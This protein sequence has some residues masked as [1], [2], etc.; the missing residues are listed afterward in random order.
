MD[1]ISSR[2]LKEVKFEFLI[3]NF[4]SKCKVDHNMFMLAQPN[5]HSTWAHSTTVK[6]PF[7]LLILAKIWITS[8][9]KFKYSRAQFES[10]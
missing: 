10:K 6:G 1:C 4:A 3:L 2:L 7:I 8:K 5:S 9:T